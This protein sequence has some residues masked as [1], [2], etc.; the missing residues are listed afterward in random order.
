MESWSAKRLGNLCLRVS[1]GG[2]PLRSVP[3]YYENGT[4]PWLKTGEVKKGLIYD[5]EEKITE[6][7]LEN[8]STKLIPA[9]SV[10]VAMYGDGDTAGNVAINKVPLTTNQACCNFTLNP[11]Q[12]NYRFVYYY[13]KGSY[14]NLINLKL[15]GS[16][17]NLNAQSLKSF[18]INHPAVKTQKKIAAILSAYDELIENNQRRIA[19]LEKMAEEIYREWFVRL[20]FPG[21][22]KVKFVKGM[23]DGW[24]PVP[25][26]KVFN[27]LSGGTPNTDNPVYWDGHIPFFTP[28]DAGENYYILKAEKSL[29]QKGLDS[30]NSR[31]YKKDTIFITARGTVGKIG[32]AYRNMAMNQSCY[33]LTTRKEGAVYFYFLS[34]KNAIAYI[35]GVSKSG[36]FDNIIVD[37][38]KVVPIFMP[39]Q[40]L[41]ARFNEIATPIFRQLGVLS[42]VNEKL[43]KIRDMLLPR[44]ISGKL[45]VENLDIQFPPGMVEPFHET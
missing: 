26:N 9:N 27:V 28:R 15:G 4:I 6:N 23:P 2:T 42:E 5:T 41:I 32:L 7:G 30:C 31:L 29:T 37:T 1:S 18:P 38:F 21:H 25:S 36:V 14:N 40:P 24:Q 20:R 43:I 33:A 17:Q 16:Q 39:P 35:K 3:A 10:I 13:L 11:E 44:L 8:S 22:E 45:S 34:M 19:L 12:A